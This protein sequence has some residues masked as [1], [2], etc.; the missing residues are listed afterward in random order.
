MSG[1]LVLGVES[2]GSLP[3]VALVEQD[4][5][6]G[7]R[8]VPMEGTRHSSALIEVADGLFRQSKVTPSDLGLVAVSIGPGSFT[9]LRIGVTFAKTLAYVAGCQVAGINSLQILAESVDPALAGDA[10]VLHVVKDAQRGEWFY[11]AFQRVPATSTI[12]H[13][14]LRLPLWNIQGKRE[15][16][17]FESLAARVKSGDIIA[18]STSARHHDALMRM[19]QGARHVECNPLAS[20]VAILGVWS[21]ATH[22]APWSLVPDYGRPSSAEE[23]KSSD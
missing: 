4:R 15:I 7:E 3:M 17:A 19:P 21:A 12:G 14:S 8:T 6:L 11:Q 9:G 13:G 1:E 20:K 22:A 23:K 5:V 10:K 2:S 16:I 18:S